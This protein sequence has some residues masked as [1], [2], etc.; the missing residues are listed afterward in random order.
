MSLISLIAFC[1]LTMYFITQSSVSKSSF[2]HIVA[3]LSFKKFLCSNDANVIYIETNAV[4][5][6]KIQI[7]SLVPNSFNSL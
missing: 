4:V 6:F 7:I 5:C 2:L 1:Y 3:S